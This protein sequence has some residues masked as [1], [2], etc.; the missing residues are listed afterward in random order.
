M[1]D[2]FEIQCVVSLTVH[3][4]KVLRHFACPRPDQ[5]KYYCDDKLVKMTCRIKAKRMFQEFIALKLG[6]LFHSSDVVSC[7]GNGVSTCSEPDAACS[8]ILRTRIINILK[9]YFNAW[10]DLNCNAKWLPVFRE[11]MFLNWVDPM[12]WI[13]YPETIGWKLNFWYLTKG[14]FWLEL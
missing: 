13:T 3:Q 1:N 4:I 10:C 7:R 2:L 11:G 12:I 14:H 8:M 6:T 5:V 9:K